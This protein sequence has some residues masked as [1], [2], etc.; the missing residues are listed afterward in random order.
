MLK[1]EIEEREL[2]DE[3]TNEFHTIK[4]TILTLEHSLISVSKWES[5]WHKPFL[6]DK[7]KTN[8]EKLDYIR[9]MSL[10]QS[11][12]PDVFKALTKDDMIAIDAYIEDPYT[13]TWFS[14][15]DKKKKSNRRGEVQTNELIYYY[16]IKLGI[17]LEPCQKWHLNRLL[18][19]IR[20]F[21]EKDRYD[22]K[23]MTRAEIAQRNKALNEARRAKLHSK[24]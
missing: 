6:D 20:V 13:A 1:L 12:D 3:R 14:G 18:T 16:M 23:K 19:L 21:T 9:C 2:F 5:K 15:D 10:T 7:P 24:G 17:P 11:V 8:E 22:N 4:P